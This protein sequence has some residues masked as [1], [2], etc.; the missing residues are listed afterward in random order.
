[1]LPGTLKC[2]PENLAEIDEPRVFCCRP[3]VYEAATT[4]FVAVY[5]SALRPENACAQLAFHQED[6]AVAL[7]HTLINVVLLF[8]SSFLLR[9]AC[10][11][12]FLSA[13]FYAVS[14]WLQ[15]FPHQS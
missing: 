14:F 5:L 4:P 7:L 13:Y 8:S 3:A 12:A 11:A 2:I 6:T 9:G 1:M 10:D 15:H